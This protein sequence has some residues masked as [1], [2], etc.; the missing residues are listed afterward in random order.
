MAE[1]EDIPAD[2]RA[3]ARR[4]PDRTRMGLSPLE[5]ELRCAEAASILAEAEE[6]GEGRKADRLRAKARL[7]LNAATPS[8]VAATLTLMNAQIREA[9]LQGADKQAARLEL[10]R[11]DFMKRHPQPDPARVLARVTAEVSRML[12]PIPPAPSPRLSAIT[13]RVGGKSKRG[14]R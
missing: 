11:D 2:L 3:L 8:G 7:I 12:P 5:L 14:H 4:V 6:T 13:R 10:E 1:V 9:R